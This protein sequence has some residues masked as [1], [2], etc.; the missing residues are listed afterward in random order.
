MLCLKLCI[1]RTN[2]VWAVVFMFHQSRLFGVTL[3]RIKG[4]EL[5]RQYFTTK[6]KRGCRDNN[7]NVLHCSYAFFPLLLQ[8]DGNQIKL[9]ALPVQYTPLPLWIC[10]RESEQMDFQLWNRVCTFTSIIVYLSFKFRNINW[11]GAN[12]KQFAPVQSHCSQNLLCVTV[13]PLD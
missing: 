11:R 10:G 3:W 4:V 5:K 2:D 7:E 6:I 1:W 9:R 13:I 8:Y 12:T